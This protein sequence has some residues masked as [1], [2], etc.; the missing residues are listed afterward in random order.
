MSENFANWD[1][2]PARV[3]KAKGGDSFS[4]AAAQP[5][6]SVG[7]SGGWE[8]WRTFLGLA[9]VCTWLAIHAVAGWG[10][11]YVVARALFGMAPGFIS[12]PRHILEVFGLWMVLGLVA[13][14]ALTWR[15]LDPEGDG[16]GVSWGTYGCLVVGCAAYFGLVAEVF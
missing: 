15:S 4:Q 7:D 8:L 1:P 9:V 2:G 3:D 14:F 11:S 16:V 13:S 5:A 10:L 12:F 6:A